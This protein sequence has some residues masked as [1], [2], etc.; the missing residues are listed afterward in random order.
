MQK[1]LEEYNKGVKRL[2]EGQCSF[3]SEDYPEKSQLSDDGY[4]AAKAR[5]ARRGNELSIHE[6]KYLLAA[7]RGDIG[8]VKRY[9]LEA[10]QLDNFNINI[11]DPLDRSAL[12]IAIEYENIE[13]IETLLSHHVEVGESLLLAINEEF[14]EA[15]ELLL[16][17]EDNG[18]SLAD[19]SV[20]LFFF[21]FLKRS[22]LMFN[23]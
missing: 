19:V 2:A 12:H 3:D 15:V 21:F 4:G 9:L 5:E 23:L 7:E 11:C 22:L 6:K 16:S 18:G 8:T 17:Y 13:M 14:V 1:L 10:S 20:L